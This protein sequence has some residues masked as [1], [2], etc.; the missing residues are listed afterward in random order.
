MWY[1]QQNWCAFPL[2]DCKAV[3]LCSVCAF[4]TF[5][6]PHL[7]YMNVSLLTLLLHHHP[8]PPALWFSLLSPASPTS[9]LQTRLVCLG[10]ISP[11]PARS[12]NHTYYNTTISFHRFQ[13]VI[14]VEKKKHCKVLRT[15]GFYLWHNKDAPQSHV[16]FY[17]SSLG[18]LP[19]QTRLCC[20][21]RWDVCTCCMS[22]MF[23]DFSG[24]MF[25]WCELP[26][27][28]LFGGF[29][30]N[31]GPH[32]CDCIRCTEVALTHTCVWARDLVQSAILSPRQ[33]GCNARGGHER[34]SQHHLPLSGA[35]WELSF[36]LWG[37]R[38]Y[39]ETSRINS[40]CVRVKCSH[41]CCLVELIF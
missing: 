4:I 1:I 19:W 25:L 41:F 14:V 3:L 37:Y 15:T 23:H 24:R 13:N 35:W 33:C 20:C 39:P 22:K 21:S 11:T 40:L 7:D 12:A 9:A 16:W 10:T 26:T 29:C 5:F 18:S 34:P 17:F 38:V 36:C 30:S 2:F 32:L 8:L 6:F 27:C 28:I 31:T